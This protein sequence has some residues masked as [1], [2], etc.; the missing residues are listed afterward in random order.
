MEPQRVE[1]TLNDI[2]KKLGDYSKVGINPITN[3]PMV[4]KS[5]TKKV[6]KMLESIK[7]ELTGDW[8]KERMEYLLYRPIKVHVGYNTETN[9]WID[10]LSDNLLELRTED[11][12][13]QIFPFDDGLMVHSLIV[14]DDKRK[15]GIGSKIMNKLYDISEE[16]GIPLYIIP[17]PAI[18]S[19]DQS[20]IFELVDPLHKWYEQLGFGL[21]EDRGLL[22]CNY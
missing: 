9:F 8:Y 21:L 6:Q 22:W 20:K 17:F 16:M 15:H 11:Y 3:R 13:L 2:K 19:Y 5:T 4:F 18:D 12:Q 7:K 14:N 10:Y 1:T